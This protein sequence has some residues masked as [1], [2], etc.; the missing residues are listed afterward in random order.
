MKYKFS[1]QKNVFM[2]NH[3]I[4]CIY[5]TETF[6]TICESAPTKEKTILLWPDDFGLSTNQTEDL[7]IDLIEWAEKQKFNYIIHR[8]KRC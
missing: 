6:R 4:T 1:L 7:I 3:E 5:G 2:Y 8:G